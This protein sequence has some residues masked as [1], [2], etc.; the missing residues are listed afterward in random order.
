MPRASANIERK[1]YECGNCK[2]GWKEYDWGVRLQQN[3][4]LCNQIKYPNKVSVYI[5]FE[6]SIVNVSNVYIF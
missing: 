6:L 3:C 2:V 5:S 1:I 4:P